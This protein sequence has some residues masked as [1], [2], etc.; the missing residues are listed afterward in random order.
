MSRTT[1]RSIGRNME[2]HRGRLVEA[3]DVLRELAT[4]LALRREVQHAGTDPFRYRSIVQHHERSRMVH[5]AREGPQSIAVTFQ[6]DDDEV[7]RHE[8]HHSHDANTK[9]HSS[10]VHCSAI[11][12]CMNVSAS[13]QGRNDSICWA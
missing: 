6:V 1:S 11:E 9:Y 12:P 7:Q 4:I 13:N 3:L 10:N 8:C 5:W 2:E